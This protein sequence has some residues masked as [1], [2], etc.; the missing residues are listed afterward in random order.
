[1]RAALQL[2]LAAVTCAAS[3][4]AA[5][6][7]RLDNAIPGDLL[8]LTLTQRTRY[9]YLSEQFRTSSVG[10]P[11]D[12]VVVLRT[13][14]HG[15]LQP[16]P[17]VALG[18]ELQDSRAYVTDDTALN[19]TVVNAVELLRAYAELRREDVFGGQLRLSGGRMT[20]DVGSRRLVAR[21]IF[22]N[23]INGFTGLDLEWTGD[24]AGGIVCRAF[25][26]LPV[27]RLPNDQAALQDNEVE[28]DEESTDAQF[29]GLFAAG[30]SRFGFDVDFS[31]FGLHEDDVATHPLNRNLFT[32]G[33]RLVREPSAGQFDYEVEFALQWGES[34]YSRSAG[35]DLDHFAH[36]E[37]LE[38]GYRFDAPWQP[39]LAV[40][41]DYASGDEDP[42][43]G[44]NGRF[45]TLFGARRF[46]FG[47]TGIYGPFARSNLFTA[48][49][50]VQVR[51]RAAVSAFLAY[52]A[53]WL[54]QKRDRW[55]TSG[56]WDPSG[57]SGRFLGHQVEVRGR[58]RPLPG[59]LLLE[60]GWAHLFRGEFARTA[61]NAV[62]TRD[63]DYFYTQAVI[64]L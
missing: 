16:M 42:T 11:E 8:S 60:V 6:P 24:A 1:L 51:P 30:R 9:E 17:G 7:W 20:M 61:P 2:V 52:R 63:S 3:A 14:L 55:T 43:D 49:G 15:R 32:A 5:E 46:E 31:L 50:R 64:W 48:G 26:T 44:R 21:N 25:W 45:D 23:T 41:W 53:F 47:P 37:H 33:G 18:A 39:R 57:E 40:Q 58:W 34:R 22:R 12:Q 38:V 56:V 36:F 35:V 62:A 59:N 4:A 29:W 19:T 28:F 27:R 13:L 10:D 54:A